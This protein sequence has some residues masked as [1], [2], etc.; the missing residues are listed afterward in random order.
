[1][2]PEDKSLLAE[3]LK[4][5]KNPQGQ[6]PE[7]AVRLLE[8]TCARTGLD[9][10]Q[11]H[12]YLINRGGK[13]QVTVSIDGF[14]LVANQDPEYA[15]QEG[16]FWTLGPD[17]PWTDIPPTKP[18]YAAKV[19]IIRNKNGQLVTTWG[20]AKYDDYNAGSPMWRKFASTMIAKCAEM[21]G[22]RKALPGRLGGLYGVEE[23]DQA[24]PKQSARNS[25]VQGTEKQ[26][27]TSDDTE[28]ED[29][30]TE[31]TKKIQEQSSL[32]DLKKLGLELSKLNL[33]LQVKQ[34]LSLVYNDRKAKLANG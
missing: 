28:G 6:A 7:V 29:V 10:K 32:E 25:K 23:M 21:L 5:D 1:V 26:A 14:R 3:M 31:W 20:V 13:W 11:R 18:P 33:G 30:V 17:Q 8:E 22:L 27:E 2:S 34:Q 24:A 4:N 9:W 16:P 15:G 19:G 12:V